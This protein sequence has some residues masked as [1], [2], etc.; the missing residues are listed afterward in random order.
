MFLRFD[1]D[2]DMY[3]VLVFLLRSRAGEQVDWGEIDS[4]PLNDL[5]AGFSIV[6]DE[7][8]APDGVPVGALVTADA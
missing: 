2:P 1:E 5:M 8:P 4:I 7:S 3:A 6:P